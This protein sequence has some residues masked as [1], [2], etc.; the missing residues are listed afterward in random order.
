[1][2]I[3]FNLSPFITYNFTAM[4]EYPHRLFLYLDLCLLHFFFL[5]L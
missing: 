1:M 3:I 2:D 4:C 5:F